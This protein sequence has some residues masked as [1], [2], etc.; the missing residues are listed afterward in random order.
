MAHHEAAVFYLGPVKPNV[1]I[2]RLERMVAVDPDQMHGFVFDVLGRF[3]G[4]LAQ[5]LP[6]G[7]PRRRI[8]HDVC[9][10]GLPDFVAVG[11]VELIDGIVCLGGFPGVDADDFVEMLAQQARGGAGEGA[12]FHGGDRLVWESGPRQL[13]N[14]FEG[15]DVQEGD[16][17][18][19]GLEAGPAPGGIEAVPGKYAHG[20]RGLGGARSPG[21]APGPSLPVM[22]LT[23]STS[24]C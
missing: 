2:H 10:E 20:V 19:Q 15:G 6:D 1:L 17:V 5:D 7:E 12:D 3:L 22:E 16:V 18:A 24:C 4:S 9:Q 13:G 11:L 8:A 21:E 14:G 23:K